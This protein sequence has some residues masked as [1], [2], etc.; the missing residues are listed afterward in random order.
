[1]SFPSALMYLKNIHVQKGWLGKCGFCFVFCHYCFFTVTLFLQRPFMFT[2]GHCFDRK[3]FGNPQIHR[4]LGGGLAAWQDAGVT[5][6]IP[7][8]FWRNSVLKAW[9]VLWV[10]RYRQNPYI[11]AFLDEENRAASITLHLCNM[12]QAC[13]TWVA[14]LCYWSVTEAAQGEVQQVMA[15]LC[16]TLP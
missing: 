7:K 16:F 6:T 9:C 3:M 11:L 4:R 12:K 2:L 5:L 10:T 1:M 8:P 13:H 15:M 14:L